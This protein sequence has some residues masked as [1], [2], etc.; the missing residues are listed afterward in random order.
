MMFIRPALLFLSEAWL[1][2][3]VDVYVTLIQWDG[4]GSL[5]FVF[6]KLSL[7]TEGERSTFLPNVT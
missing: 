5:W 7:L 1:S 2:C 4:S 6:A 3:S